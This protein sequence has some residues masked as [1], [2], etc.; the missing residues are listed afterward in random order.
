MLFRSLESED[1]GTDANAYLGE[2]DP[3]D[4]IDGF[5]SGVILSIITAGTAQEDEEVYRQRREDYYGVREFASNKKFWI[6]ELDAMDV[7]GGCKPV[8]AATGG[9]NIAIT[10]IGADYK[11]PTAAVVAAVQQ[12]A[13]PLTKTAEGEGLAA[14]GAAV[15]ISG[16]STTTINIT[17]KI[18]FSDGITYTDIQSAV[19]AAIDAYFI[20]LGK[21][22]EDSTVPLV[23]RVSQIELRLLEVE[24]ITDIENITINGSGSNLTLAQNYLPVRGTITCS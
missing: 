6:T 11:A 13:D 17:A 18:T 23:V 9:G 14:I 20:D 7:V 22:W 19:E 2:I 24:G 3:I 1:P 10:I 15:V 16:C 5:E 21:S 4:Y 8:R 12:A